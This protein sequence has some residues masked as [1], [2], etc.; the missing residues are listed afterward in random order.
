MTDADE[1]AYIEMFTKKGGTA[2]INYMHVQKLNTFLRCNG[3]NERRY[4]IFHLSCSGFMD[5]RLDSN[6]LSYENCYEVSPKFS[7]LTPKNVT[8]ANAFGLEKCLKIIKS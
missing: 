2:E 7:R 5:Q 6:R 4:H 8:F 1:E 3:C